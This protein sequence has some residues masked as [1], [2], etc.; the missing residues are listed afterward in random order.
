MVD[1]EKRGPIGASP[2]EISAILEDRMGL[3]IFLRMKT[4]DEATADI[5]KVDTFTD[6]NVLDAPKRATAP[7]AYDPRPAGRSAQDDLETEA[8]K[9]K[10]DDDQIPW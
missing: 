1:V 4:M 5:L 10:S 9:G 8:F 6:P 7:R 2:E 3:G